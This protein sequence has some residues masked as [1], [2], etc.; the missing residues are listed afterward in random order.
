M[1]LDFAFRAAAQIGIELFRLR[2]RLLGDFIDGRGRGLLFA[3]TVA[4]AERFEFVQAHG[5][6]DVVIQ[7]AQARV[8]IEIEPAGQQLVERL[9][10]LLA[11]FAKMAGLEILLAGVERRLALRRELF[12]PV[13]EIE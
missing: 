2:D 9:I 12:R 7:I 1:A 3:E 10:K 8:G 5:V 13:R 4:G 11:R 6:H